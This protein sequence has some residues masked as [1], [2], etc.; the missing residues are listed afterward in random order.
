MKVIPFIGEHKSLRSSNLFIYLINFLKMIFI[1]IQCCIMLI[2]KATA[3]QICFGGQ[4]LLFFT[5]LSGFCQFIPLFHTEKT[6][7]RQSDFDIYL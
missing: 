6:G 4:F 7:K 1:S 3:Y 2:F 5:L